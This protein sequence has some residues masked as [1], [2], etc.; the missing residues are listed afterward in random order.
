MI[1]WWWIPIVFIVGALF[2]VVVMAVCAADN[3]N[4]NADG[5]RWWEE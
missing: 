4:R 2:G 3:A 1:A 5:K